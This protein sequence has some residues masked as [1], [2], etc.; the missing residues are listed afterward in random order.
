MRLRADNGWC[1]RCAFAALAV[2]DYSALGLTDIIDQ[3]IGDIDQRSLEPMN[4]Q[5][6]SWPWPRSVHGELAL[7][8]TVLS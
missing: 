1:W 3:R 4:E 5:A 8:A 6:G 7:K 2:A